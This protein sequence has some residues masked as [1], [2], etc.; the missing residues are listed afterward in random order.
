[1]DKHTVWC[2]TASQEA[3]MAAHRRYPLPTPHII[4]ITHRKDWKRT[5]FACQRRWRETHQ[6]CQLSRPHTHTHWL[7]GDIFY[8]CFLPGTW[9]DALQHIFFSRWWRSGPHVKNNRQERKGDVICVYT[10]VKMSRRVILLRG[11]EVVG[12]SSAPRQTL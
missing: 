5:S 12:R 4:G 9:M 11:G 1:M 10:N 8:I 7:T 6:I 3:V 2:L